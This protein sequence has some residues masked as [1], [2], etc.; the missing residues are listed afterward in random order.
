VNTTILKTK[1]SKS[2]P[3]R[4]LSDEL[5]IIGV[6]LDLGADR[7]GVDMGPSAIRYAGLSEKL[8]VLGSK[9]LDRGNIETPIAEAISVEHPRAK[10]LSNVKEVCLKLSKEVTASVRRNKLPLVL[11]GD[12]SIAI[13]TLAGIHNGLTN[14]SGEDNFGVIWLDAHGDFN[15]PEISPSGNIHGMSLAFAAGQ[16]TKWFPAP[17]PKRS[18]DPKRITIVGARQ[19]DPK[20][21]KNL[22][23]MGV[24][25]LS[26]ADID[27]SGMKAVMSEAIET[28]SDGGRNKIHVSLDMDLVDP[29]EAPGVG[30][31]V[32]GGATYREAH[33]AMEMIHESRLM[34][35]LE[36]VE[37]NPILDQ[38][39]ATAEL[40][41]ELI[42][43]AMGKRII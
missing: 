27:R 38:E 37:V 25:V 24:K 22:R 9:V 29:S 32:R 40:A 20:E 6:P 13:G 17:W 11:G 7:R 5:E 26:M 4:I 34:R 28:S 23:R 39:N 1:F 16:G 18:V 33:L 2:F 41:V 19:L 14:S 21:Q 42:L 30:T 35:S 15:T 31:P 43:S 36:V 3:R 8:H 12:H 10:Y